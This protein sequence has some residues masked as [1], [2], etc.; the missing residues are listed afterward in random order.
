MRDP[1][2]L[3]DF[4]FVFVYLLPAQVL[5]LFTWFVSIA[6]KQPALVEWRRKGFSWALFV[7]TG[8]TAWFFA[9]SVH[10]R[11]KGEPPQG[12]WLFMNRL[13]LVVLV[14]CLAA[15]LTGKGARR[16]LLF[17]WGIVLFAGVL[18]IALGSSP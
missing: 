13:G 14:F 10:Y 3:D 16:V 4:I 15:S 12:V 1:R 9:C 5:L 11:S 2:N 8:L 7:A 17:A 18:G 6:K